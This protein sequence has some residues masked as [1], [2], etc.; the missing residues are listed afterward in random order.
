M[1]REVVTIVG[2]SE[3]D[4]DGY[5]IIPGNYVRQGVVPIFIRCRDDYGNRVHYEWLEA[6][7]PVAEA[8]RFLARKFLQDEWRV[9][10]IA[11]YVVHMLSRRYGEC[12]G[13][14]PGNQIFVNA[15][16]RAKDLEVGG[17]RA[18][19][20][21]DV[22]LNEW[23]VQQIPDPT[24]L[25]RNVENQDLAARL[26]ELLMESNRWDQDQLLKMIRL[27]RLDLGDE[28]SGAFG[29]A[30]GPAGYR[31]KN[32]LKK[33]FFRVMRRLLEQIAEDNEQRAETRAKRERPNQ[34]APIP[35]HYVR[36]A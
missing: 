8:L 6:V 4:S 27:Y 24:D 12:L 7:E 31:G 22:E 21:R 36:A 19:A 1:I 5:V 32:T 9:S 26:E 16:W 35:R 13:D 34:S 23:K 3:D 33:R 18:R 29:I 17:K 10:E 25:A 30:E 2:T 14:S 20:F 28:L 11:E 15:K